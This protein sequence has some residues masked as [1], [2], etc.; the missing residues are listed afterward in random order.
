MTTKE[1]A[2]AD[3]LQA[4]GLSPLEMEAVLEISQTRRVKLQ[5]YIKESL[6]YYSEYL[7][8]NPEDI[9]APMSID[10]RQYAYIPKVRS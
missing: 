8:N 4:L 6:L 7:L 3:I 10:L 1:G 2:S 5:K 9:T